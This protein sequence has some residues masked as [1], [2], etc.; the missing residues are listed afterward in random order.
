MGKAARAFL[1]ADA[2]TEIALFL[3]VDEGFPETRFR[4]SPEVCCKQR[5]WEGGSGDA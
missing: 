3:R 4:F 5:S 2:G 1:Q